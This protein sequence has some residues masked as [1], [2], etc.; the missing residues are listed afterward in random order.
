MATGPSHGRTYDEQ[1]FSPLDSI[2]A[3][4]VGQLGLAWYADVDSD[5]AQEGTPLAIDGKLYV[6][7]AWSRVKAYDAVT[8]KLLWSY[9]PQVPRETQIKACCTV[10]SRGLAAWGDRL[11]LGALGRAPHRARSR[12]GQARLERHD[13]RPDEELFRD[14]RAARRERPRHRRQ[15]RRRSPWRARLCHGL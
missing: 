10:A 15:W 5:G 2:N 14:R 6:V 8:G 3:G 4:N 9:D 13:R 7:T 11:F 1:R 12:H